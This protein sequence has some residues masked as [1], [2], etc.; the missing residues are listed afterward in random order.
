M[1]VCLEQDWLKSE[2]V[3]RGKES[4]VIA[5]PEGAKQSQEVS[6]HRIA[7]INEYSSQLIRE[8][9]IP[10]LT[11]EVN[12]S[13]RYSELRQV[14]YSLVLAQWAK[15]RL[16]VSVER[17]ADSKDLSGLT[18]R[19]PWSKQEY[20]NA[21]CASFERG[22]YN[23]EEQ[24][25]T[26][27]GISIRRYFSGGFSGVVPEMKVLYDR[28]GGFAQTTPFDERVI[29]DKT[30]I[31][32]L[33]QDP[34]NKAVAEDINARLQGLGDA[35]AKDG[36]SPADDP[37]VTP[38]VIKDLVRSVEGTTFDLYNRGFVAMIDKATGFRGNCGY[39]SGD[40]GK[41][42][43]YFRL[44]VRVY[45]SNYTY[46]I[47]MTEKQLEK[48]IKGLVSFEN[49]HLARRLVVAMNQQYRFLSKADIARSRQKQIRRAKNP[50]VT[51]ALV[52]QLV[53]AIAGKTV[54]LSDR[55]LGEKICHKANIPGRVSYV[56]GHPGI[57]TSYC[58][59]GFLDFD[60]GYTS[61]FD[62]SAE[63]FHGFIAELVS[64]DR[65]WANDYVAF[66]EEKLLKKAKDGGTE[67]VQ[68][69][70]RDSASIR[71]GKEDNSQKFGGVDF[72]AM[73]IVVQTAGGAAGVI[74]QMSVAQL[75][76][77]WNGI[78]KQLR[79][80]NVPYDRLK[81]YVAACAQNK[82]AREQ[83]AQ[84]TAYIHNILRLEEDAAYE[85]D[86]RMADILAI[87]G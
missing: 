67:D 50:K 40:A 14:F 79:S 42:K 35:Q 8:L 22:E 9:V 26:Q 18:S 27:D 85:T 36:G 49:G 52:S 71:Q 84:V 38:K 20:Y 87:S 60:S 37:L 69:S 53:T 19:Q 82:E 29:V 64:A 1:K 48:F 78:V 83:F 54:F 3:V 5:S 61:C 30:G 46:Y 77:D 44:A 12:S 34:G 31:R 74:P 65:N 7:Q 68:T 75:E 11:R 17:L 25:R 45:D 16:A 76:K 23:K 56:S 41:P 6:D 33:A 73:P 55:V 47:D 72:R 24:V 13:K 70:A 81:M 43:G 28:D 62:M 39:T 66:L 59:L 2:C 4:T 32:P 86:P 63:Q 21:Y 80:G 10:Q 15:K 57:G 51:P 58:R